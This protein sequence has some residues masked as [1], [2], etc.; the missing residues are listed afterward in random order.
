M[1]ME[2]LYIKNVGMK[3]MRPRLYRV[4]IISSQD[5]NL[6]TVTRLDEETQ[7]YIERTYQASDYS[8]DRIRKVHREKYE[9]DF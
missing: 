5:G 4:V 3:I 8:A 2:E 6:I 7:I 9:K 1:N